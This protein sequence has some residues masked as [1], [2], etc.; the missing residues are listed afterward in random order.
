MKLK[1]LLHIVGND[2]SL[3]GNIREMF[4]NQLG[5]IFS[6]WVEN[7]VSATMFPKVG[8]QKNIDRNED[9]K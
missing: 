7:F 6:S 3:A 8:K 1:I 9:K 5:N 2:L 4:S